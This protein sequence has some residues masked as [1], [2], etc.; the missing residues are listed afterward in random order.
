MHLMNNTLL[1]WLPVF[2]VQLNADKPLSI[3]A[4]AFMEKL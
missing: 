2:T 3:V 1:K 4:V